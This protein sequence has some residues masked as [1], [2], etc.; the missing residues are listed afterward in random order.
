MT[1]ST[2]RGGTRRTPR[3]PSSIQTWLA[4]ARNTDWVAARIAFG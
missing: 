1:C 2:A 3:R 4:P